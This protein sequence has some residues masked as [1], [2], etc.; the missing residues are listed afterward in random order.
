MAKSPS[1]LNPEYIDKLLSAFIESEELFTK[2]DFD[3]IRPIIAESY[4]D[5]LDVLKKI[6]GTQNLRNKLASSEYIA[7]VLAEIISKEDKTI[8][9]DSLA[10]I[11]I[12]EEVFFTQEVYSVAILTIYK[13][14][15]EEMLTESPPSILFDFF[16]RIVSNIDIT[17][18]N[19]AHYEN[20][21]E[22]V[23]DCFIEDDFEKSKH[24]FKY[25]YAYLNGKESDN[26]PMDAVEENITEFI[27]VSNP[28]VII[29]NIKTASDI[30]V[31]FQKQEFQRALTDRVKFDYGFIE[32]FYE[33]MSE[34]VKQKWIELWLPLYSEKSVDDFKKVFIIVNNDIPDKKQLGEKILSESERLSGTDDKVQLLELFMKL[35][36]AKSD[37]V[38]SN[39]KSQVKKMF[40][41]DNTNIH[42]KGYEILKNN[43]DLFAKNEIEDIFESGARV[44][45]EDLESLHKAFVHTLDNDSP[46][47]N[48]F[49]NNLYNEYKSDIVSF[50][51]T[52]S[53]Y[54]LEIFY[55]RLTEDNRKE[56]LI[57]VIKETSNSATSNII[58]LYQP[59][60][61]LLSKA[62]I[63]DVTTEVRKVILNLYDM[64]TDESLKLSASLYEKVGGISIENMNENTINSLWGTYEKNPLNSD[65]LGK[66]LN[67]IFKI[68]EEKLKIREA[69]YYT[70]NN[71]VDVTEALNNS[72][73]GNIL[74]AKASN[75]LKS[76][77]EHGV[78]KKLLI[79]YK[80][81]NKKAI[82][83]EYS[84]GDLIFIF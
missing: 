7:R 16:K 82:E 29:D 28:T 65:S 42:N 9:Y 38:F 40:I 66:M 79:K 12:Y 50:F 23:K 59:I 27:K 39:Y 4:N 52:I 57:S 62:I 18:E 5:K 63:T 77:P 13:P 54:F 80:K 83:K 70:E 35:D 15:L 51:S 78:Q 69:I 71:S 37:A 74:V 8:F 24:V 19:K 34:K 33:F 58:E 47:T 75:E 36:I 31:F 45:I 60:D 68:D 76:D 10:I 43:E 46:L 21:Y 6:S 67:S 26:A 53:V 44:F 61:K 84:E 11:N 25:Y 48:E 64:N 17:E 32:P 72:I 20:V 41:S 81:G 56:L 55:N 14:I 49:F 2:T 3:K 73:K 22:Y 1:N 30:D